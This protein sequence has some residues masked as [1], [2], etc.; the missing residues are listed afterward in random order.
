MQAEYLDRLRDLAAHL[1]FDVDDANAAN[2]AYFEWRESGDAR[3]KKT[4]DL[5]TYCYAQLY[6]LKRLSRD[7]AVS[8]SDFDALNEAVYRRLLKGM[9]SVR[10]TKRYSHWVNVVCRNTYLNGRRSTRTHAEINDEILMAEE[11]PAFSA[12]DRA[13]IND[14]VSLAMS[15]LPDAI[16][17][18]A[19]M[20]LVE[21][22]PYDEIA[23]EVGKPIATVR[24]Y[25]G[26]AVSKLRNDIELR[27]FSVDLL[28]GANIII[29]DLDDT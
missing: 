11:A 26:K 9:D 24:A 1:P 27:H 8:P 13:A 4:V 20:R 22:R 17:G 16:R 19:R 3:Q 2:Q 29:D 23:E 15:K 10:D 25:V 5:W 28:P 6:V 7:S 21:E 12:M 14:S 18:I